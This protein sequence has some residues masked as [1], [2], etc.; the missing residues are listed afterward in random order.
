[1]FSEKTKNITPLLHWR[2]SLAEYCKDVY[3]LVPEANKNNMR[4]DLSKIETWSAEN[5]VD[6]PVLDE[7]LGGR[8]SMYASNLSPG[9][10][11]AVFAVSVTTTAT[12]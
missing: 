7:S 12:K 9:G 5:R 10:G 3:R 4:A 2:K 1:M 8:M 11:S 6:L